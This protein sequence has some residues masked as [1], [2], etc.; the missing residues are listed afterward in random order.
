[1]T[2]PYSNLERSN[3]FKDSFSLLNKHYLSNSRLPLLDILKV[4]FFSNFCL[5][6]I[7]LSIRSYSLISEIKETPF[8]LLSGKLLAYRWQF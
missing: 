7:T 5:N 8:D 6:K 1:M 2:P 4:I 3:S